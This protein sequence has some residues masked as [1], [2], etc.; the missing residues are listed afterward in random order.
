MASNKPPKNKNKRW[1]KSRRDVARP[2]EKG[3]FSYTPD[4]SI[5]HE[6][7]EKKSSRV[8]QYDYF[9]NK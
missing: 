8:S 4:V 5:P 1:K 3:Y 6:K 9:G 2:N 7:K